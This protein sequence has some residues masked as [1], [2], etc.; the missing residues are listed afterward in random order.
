MKPPI[1][2][3]RKSDD[4]RDVM[5]QACEH[6]ADGRLVAFPTEALYVVA[7]APLVDGVAANFAAAGLSPG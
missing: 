6:L 2:E 5:H 7:G 1:L 4:P 3:F